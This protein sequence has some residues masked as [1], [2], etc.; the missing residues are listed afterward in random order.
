MQVPIYSAANLNAE[1]DFA[2]SAYLAK[3][4]TV[5]TADAANVQS[6]SNEANTGGGNAGGD[7][8]GGGGTAFGEASTG[9]GGGGG[10][11]GGVVL[12][13]PKVFQWFARDFGSGTAYE[14]AAVA[15]GYLSGKDKVTLRACLA[16]GSRPDLSIVYAKFSFACSRLAELKMEV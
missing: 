3:T 13:L 4:V 9:G 10:N 6:A 7:T 12:T 2:S 16:D 5:T 15:M 11:T 1:L 14:G 8:T